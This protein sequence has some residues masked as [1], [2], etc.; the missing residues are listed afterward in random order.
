MTA[1]YL[2]LAVCAWIV[3]SLQPCRGATNDT[4]RYVEMMQDIVNI[5]SGQPIAGGE[6]RE[7]PVSAPHA[8][9]KRTLLF[10]EIRMDSATHGGCNY[11]MSI[12]LNGRDLG[13]ARDW[14]NQRLIGKTPM[15]HVKNY[16]GV[17]GP[18]VRGGQWLL[19]YAP[20]FED[21]QIEEGDDCLFFWD[22][23][24][25]L[26]GDGKDDIRIESQTKRLEEQLNRPV[27]LVLGRFQ[28]GWVDEKVLEARLGKPLFVPPVA[29]GAKLSGK[30][31]SCWLAP[32]GGMVVSV[33]KEPFLLRSRFT[34]P[35]RPKGGWNVLEPSTA[36]QGEPGWKPT[37]RKSGDALSVEAKGATYS[38]SRKLT[39]D[40][41]RIIVRDSFRNVTDDTIGFRFANELDCTGKVVPDVAVSGNQSPDYSA[42][43]NPADN[44]TLFVKTGNAGLGLLIEDDVFR[45][46]SIVKF[47]YPM[48]MI[49]SNNFG[50]AA[51]ASYTVEWAIYPTPTG[52]AWDFINQVRRDWNVNFTI[53]AGSFWTDCSALSRIPDDSLKQYIDWSGSKWI[54]ATPWLDTYPLPGRPTYEQ[55]VEIVRPVVEKLKRICPDAKLLLGTHPT[56]NFCPPG[57]YYDSEEYRD[58]HILDENWKHFWSKTYTDYYCIG[59]AK[60]QGFL[61]FCN[62]T[63]PGNSYYRKMTMEA[64]VALDRAGAGGIYCDEFNHYNCV[65]PR[66][67]GQWDQHYVELDNDT[68]EVKTDKQMAQLSLVTDEAQEQYANYILKKCGVFLANAQPVTRRMQNLHFPRFVETASVER[69]FHS[70]LFSPLA[71]G[72]NPPST[73]E[74]ALFQV[75]RERVECCV[76]T[77][78]GGM[79]RLTRPCVTARMFPFTPVDIRPGI[80]TGNERIVTTRSGSYGWA[81]PFKARLFVYDKSGALSEAE[82][83][84][85]TC[86]KKMN[87]TV[88]AEGMAIV[89]K[90]D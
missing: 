10:L 74:A 79:P 47:A 65:S 77:H 34:Y 28:L 62:Y 5:P 66:T 59:V 15:A 57:K 20:S 54:M 33:G 58:S 85:Q 76:L 12:R 32:G 3:V 60:E 36:T 37:V 81:T 70:A 73:D 48:G 17:E 83:P 50:L 61:N 24:D 7:F 39:L 89:E 67:Y 18:W 87:I 11:G 35:G 63:T 51:K 78:I 52:D 22:V 55:L 31:F 26:R 86:T 27:P 45:V 19:M 1:R 90:V 72:N 43:Q 84:P 49:G 29:D 13:T 8:K 82:P 69:G 6:S 56:M 21:K 4:R 42:S 30:G 40:R 44:P 23:T 2:I 71:Y 38:L 68:F 41:H 80:M 64:D 25:L 46:Q 88:P 75:V 9:G 16:A 53:P 14:M